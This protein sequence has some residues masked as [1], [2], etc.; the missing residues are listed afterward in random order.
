MKWI[1]NNFIL[2]RLGYYMFFVGI[3]AGLVKDDLGVILFFSSM[4]LVFVGVFSFC[5]RCKH[6]LFNVN[7]FERDILICKAIIFKKIECPFCESKINDKTTK[8]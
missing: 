8:S 2:F 4:G 5:P 6:S 7:F 3:I 1:L